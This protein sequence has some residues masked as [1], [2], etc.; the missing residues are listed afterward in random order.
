MK[1]EIYN[2]E[3]SPTTEEDLIVSVGV[4]VKQY[5]QP[6]EDGA[7]YREKYVIGTISFVYDVLEEDQTKDINELF[8]LIKETNTYKEAIG[9]EIYE[10]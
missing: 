3:L 4:T 9:I 7:I 5:S 8:S 1:R 10:D 2:A 6:P